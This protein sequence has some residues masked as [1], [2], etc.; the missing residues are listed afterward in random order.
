M[1][2]LLVGALLWLL[3]LT[4][5]TWVYWPGLAGPP[6][7]DDAANLRPLEL[8]VDQPDLITDVVAGNLSGP[9]G[10]PLTMLSFSLEQV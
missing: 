5:C 3:A 7:L 1:Q 4:L 8:L 9:L 6:L 10:R 2:S